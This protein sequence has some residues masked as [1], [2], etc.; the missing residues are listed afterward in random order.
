MSI[1]AR[2][3]TAFLL[4]LSFSVPARPA[5]RVAIRVDAHVE[6]GALSPMWAW[7]GYD[8]PNYTYRRV[9]RP[10]HVVTA[11]HPQEDA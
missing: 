1:R 4:A 2:A 3:V 5:D 10:F 7:F 8:E 6:R 11:P 9:A